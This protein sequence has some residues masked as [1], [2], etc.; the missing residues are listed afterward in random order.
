M[1]PLLQ[2][3]ARDLSPYL[4]MQDDDGFDPASASDG[5]EEPEFGG[6][7]AFAEGVQFVTDAVG[8]GEWTVPLFLT[9][10]DRPS[11]HQLKRDIE[12]EL[13]KGSQVAFAVDPLVDPVSYFDLERG[14][15]TVQFQYFMAIQSA[16]RATLRLWTRPYANT[17]TARSVAA[18]SGTGPQ[19]F[20]A[21]G[22]LGDRDALAQ[23]EVRVGSNVAS[24]GRVVG[25]GIARSA[26]FRGLRLASSLSAQAS[27]SLVAEPT[28][29]VGSG[30][31][32]IPVSP[33]G[34]SGIAAVAYLSPPEAFVGRHRVIAPVRSNLADRSHLRIYAQDRFGAVL[35]PTVIASQNDPA[36]MMIADL[37]EIQVP[38]RASGQE[39]VPTQEIRIIAGGASGAAYAQASGYPL[40]LGGLMI[41]PLEQSPGLM[42]TQGG[43]GDSALYTD[44]FERLNYGNSLGDQPVADSGQSWV[45]GAGRM[46]AM[47][48]LASPAFRGKIG[49]GT[50]NGVGVGV[51]GA[52]NAS[53]FAALAS[54]ELNQDV[55]MEM[56]IGL[57]VL[58]LAVPSSGASGVVWEMW[59]KAIT[60]A[61]TVTDGIGAR[62]SLASGMPILSIM[63]ASGGATALVASQ[64]F[65]SQVA[66][67]HIQAGGE[68]MFG[69]NIKG[70]TAVAYLGTT[71]NGPSAL[72]LPASS[73]PG[74][75]NVGW[76]A[77]RMQNAGVATVSPTI[78]T[79]NVQNLAGGATDI[80][81][82]EFFSYESY[83]R[84]RAVQSSASA[85]VADRAADFRGRGPRIPPVGSAA[86]AGGPS[87]PA[88]VIV[89]EGALD[90]FRGNDRID[91][92]L[93][94]TE[95]FSY[96]R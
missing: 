43:G 59:P 62:L 17:A 68:L 57:K 28:S 45:V 70:A 72:V 18:I 14:H 73:V 86:G 89:F 63:T 9:A 32:N 64:Y 48:G 75:Q 15:L 47:V 2:I 51:V 3:D 42:R 39:P 16:L 1:A 31:L 33:T 56:R 90:D 85:F 69:M 55:Y 19:E 49:V 87:G 74:I 71:V 91:I 22:I 44:G 37:G 4:R 88:R 92:D 7:P 76:P 40:S 94:V 13:V 53:G 93:A 20:A 80:G 5:H 95:R 96:L 67:V 24:A 11:V 77:V 50:A 84:E 83:P 8:N 41:L 38:A 52:A 6:S 25:Y 10:S 58:T 27:S 54:G 12:S 65:A 61:S 34:A 79:V 60:N 26:S 23:L 35:G 29:P 30:T 81:P 78:D 82:R 21:T 46:G 36:K 66:S